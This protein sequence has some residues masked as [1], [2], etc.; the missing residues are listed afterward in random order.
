MLEKLQERFRQLLELQ[1]LITNSIEQE[2]LPLPKEQLLPLSR[3]LDKTAIMLAALIRL[4]A[5]SCKAP[6]DPELFLRLKA[7][8]E[9]SDPLRAENPLRS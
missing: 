6:L 4:L 7:E 3:A 5:H 1:N 2:L 8:P 9:Q